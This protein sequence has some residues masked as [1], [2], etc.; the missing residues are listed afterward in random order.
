MVTERRYIQHGVTSTYEHSKR[1]AVTALR[2]MDLLGLER[3]TNIDDVVKAALLHDYFLY[4]WHMDEPWHRM[5]GFTHGATA[6]A[7]ARRDFPEL[8]D[9]TIEDS[10]L[11]H[12]YPLTKTPPKFIEGWLITAADKT[13]A[14]AET[15]DAERIHKRKIL[16]NRVLDSLPCVPSS[17]K[18]VADYI[19]EERIRKMMPA[20]TGRTRRG[21]YKC[22]AA[23]RRAKADIRSSTSVNGE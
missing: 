23:A 11:R 7:N 1:V 8:M 10:V 14:W 21:I 19:I 22:L 15:F 5:H 9:W 20:D 12:M 3:K 13:C 17:A 2:I 6:L 16:E 4:D 18:P